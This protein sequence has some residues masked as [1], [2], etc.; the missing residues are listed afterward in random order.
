MKKFVQSLE[1]RG[2][3]KGGVGVRQRNRISSGEKIHMLKY[4]LIEFLK[5]Q[6]GV[7]KIKKKIHESLENGGWG[8][9][10]TPY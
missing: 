9:G 3:L 4:F 1:D 6:S 7:G 8:G 10:K 5:Y 2:N